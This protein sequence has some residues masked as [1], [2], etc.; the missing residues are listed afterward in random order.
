MKKTGL[1]Q[2]WLKVIAC[3]TMLMDHLG[4]TFYPGMGL[5]VVGRIAFPI[6]CFLL[7]EGVHHTGSPFRYGVRLTLAMVL[8]ELPFDCAIFG[9]PTWQHQSVMVTLLLGF[10]AL[11]LM[12]QVNNKVLKLLLGIPF[13]FLADWLH[14]DY[15]SMGLILILMLGYCREMNFGF[16]GQAMAIVVFSCLM[17][18]STLN[19]PGIRLPIELFA[20][21]SLIPIGVYSGR[22]SGSSRTVQWAFYLFYPVHL[23]VIGYFYCH[24]LPSIPKLPTF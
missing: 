7:V 20:M 10:L 19:L 15:G 4:A 16:S 13:V 2:E 12:K 11:E 5:R 17:P 23:A 1:S 14:C 8:S 6:F 21:L 22:K 3:I 24:A 18:G 9:G